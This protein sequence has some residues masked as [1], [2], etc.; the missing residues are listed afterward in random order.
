M[1][2]LFSPQWCLEVVRILRQPA[3]PCSGY[4]NTLL[5]FFQAIRFREQCVLKMMCVGTKSWNCLSPYLMGLFVPSIAERPVSWPVLWTRPN[6]FK[7]FWYIG[8]FVAKHGSSVSLLRVPFVG[9]G[10]H[11]GRQEKELWVF[12]LSL[13]FL[14]SHWLLD[15]LK[16][17]AW[18]MQELIEMWLCIQYSV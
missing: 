10:S 15:A 13:T 4:L 7:M 14:P 16:C 11:G 18:V 8:G 1:L 3:W 5:L 2:L 6:E 9:G 12:Y 17:L